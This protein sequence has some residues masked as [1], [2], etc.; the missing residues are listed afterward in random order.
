[1]SVNAQIVSAGDALETLLAG[2]EAQCKGH[3]TAS[4]MLHGR[5]GVGKTQLVT[6][7][8][9]RIGA[10]LFD[11]R[12]TTIEPQDLRGLPYYDHDAHKTVWYRPEDLPDDPS[13][14]SILFLDELTAAS[15][16]LQPTV[17]GLLQ[18]RRVGRHQLPASVFS[19]AA[20]NTVDDGAIAYEMGTALADRLIHLQVNADAKDWLERYAV[21]R[22]L[23]PMVTAFL[24]ARP[25]LL[26]TTEG[27]LRRGEMI[28]CTPR[29]WER[30]SDIVSA[31]EDRRL[32]HAMIAGTV[33]T[34]AAAEFAQI[35]AEIEALVS[36]QEILDTSPA[37]RRA[38]Y[39]TSINGLV[40]LIY[41]LVARTDADTIGRVIDI[42]A[43]LKQVEAP[44]LPL[45]ELSTF[46]FEILIR[47]AMAEGLAEAFRTSKAYREYAA[48]RAEAGAL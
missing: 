7:L 8:G 15:P 46:G 10:R 9:Q 3:L 24:R 6:E 26:D 12:L 28:A 44:G 39:P 35:A 48:E 34:A 47:K 16:H 25:D 17:Y 38:L 4:W 11:I 40:G 5:P 37:K 32:R 43:D 21:D 33:G 29:S 42:M 23:S 20:G 19:V 2:W 14:P 22:G 30:V 1:M 36:V 31:I 18:E 41:A 13:A 27:A 45:T